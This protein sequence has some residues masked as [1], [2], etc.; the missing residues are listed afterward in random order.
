MF[1]GLA[2]LMSRRVN[3]SGN[4]DQRSRLMQRY[5]ESAFSEI[6]P[7]KNQADRTR[8]TKRCKIIGQKS[9]KAKCKWLKPE[10]LNC[11]D[12][13]LQN[14]YSAVRSRPAPPTT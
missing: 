6:E 7:Q 14:L 13:V 3:R 8:F 9:D 12:K 2:L 4:S 1:T 5:V 10:L 11:E